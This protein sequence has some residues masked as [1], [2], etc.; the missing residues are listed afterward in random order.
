[1]SCSTPVAPGEDILVAAADAAARDILI[2]AAFPLDPPDDVFPDDV[3]DAPDDVSLDDVADASPDV[4]H[5]APDPVDFDVIADDNVV[6]VTIDHNVEPTN[7][8][9]PH[10]WQL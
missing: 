4:T 9:R 6:E 1:M 2:P 10:I 8:E 3:A 5:E 7:K